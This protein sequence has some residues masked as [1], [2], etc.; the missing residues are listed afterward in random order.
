M[1]AARGILT[2]S[3][4]ILITLVVHLPAA[5]QQETD[6]HRR[7]SESIALS[8]VPRLVLTS[9][10]LQCII[11]NNGLICSSQQDLGGGGGWYPT[12]TP[13]DYI[14][15]SGFQIAGITADDAGPWARDTAGAY[16][17][18]A[19]F[20]IA[21]G[22]ALTQ[23][24]DSR[25]SDD[26]ENWPAGAYIQDAEIFA[27]ILLGRKTA[28]QHDTWFQYWDGDP[29]R[30]FE[31]SHPMG[32]K[33]T[34]RSM[35][36]TYPSG[37]ESV[38][39]FMLEFENATADPEFQRLN[40][41]AYFGGDNAL[42]DEGW[43][44]NDVYVAFA[45]DHDV[46]WALQNLATAI[47]PFNMTI[48]YHGGFNAPSY[49][50]ATPSISIPPFFATSPGIAGVKYLK[51]PNDQATGEELG[52]SMVSVVTN[53]QNTPF[54]D[55]IGIP[56]LWRYLAGEFDLSLGDPT[57][58]V[59]A[60]IVSLDASRVERSVCYVP[61]SAADIRFYQAS[62][63]F[64]LAPGEKSTVIA[65]HLVAPVVETMPDGSPSGVVQSSTNFNI[66]PPGVPSFH[67]GFASARGC[68]AEGLNCTDVLSA[69]ENPVKP[70]ERA[71]GWVGYSGP[72]PSGGRYPPQ[73][74]HPT[75]R[76]DQFGVEVV[77]GS[78]LGRA[79]VAQTV[80]ENDFLLG[81][82]PERPQFYLLPGNNQV[83][84]LWDPSRTETE[85]DPFYQIAGDPESAL[86]NP[87]YREFDVEG[88]RIWRSTDRGNLELIAQFD[89]ENTRY[90]DYTCETVHPEED[91]GV[92]SV[93][94]E[95]G[96][97]LPVIGYA[98]GEICPATEENP[99]VRSI[100]G[101]L[102]FNNGGP[103]GGPGA[104]VTRNPASVA[105]DT[106]ILADRDIGEVQPLADTGVPYVYVDT[107]VYN[108]FTYFYAVTAFDLNSMASGPHSLRSSRVDQ[109]VTP[110][111]DEQNL[112]VASFSTYLAGEDGQPLSSGEIPTVDSE[113]GRFASPFPPTTAY[114][115][116]FAPVVERLLGTG[117]T[118]AVID[119][120]Q[121]RASGNLA[122]GTQE[123]PPSETCTA[124]FEAGQLANAFGGCWRIFLTTTGSDGSEEA[125]EIGG[126]TPWWN[127]FGLPGLVRGQ[128]VAATVE[129][130]EEVLESFGIDEASTSAVIDWVTGESQNYTAAEG[131]QN[132]RRGV[133]ATGAR[134]IDGDTRQGAVAVEDPSAL[135]R[136][137]HLP[138][139][140]TVWAPIPYT[141]NVEGG[142]AV[143]GFES[144]C[145]NRAQAF[146]D[147]AA[148]VVWT[149]SGGTLTARDITHNVDVPFHP[150]AGPTW[151]FLTTDAN[152]NG[153]LDWHDFNYI[154]RAYQIMRQVD[155]G[156]C[157]AFAGGR[158][159]AAGTA[160]P[161]FL[162]A[163]PSL[164]PT[165]TEGMADAGSIDFENGA[166]PPQTGTGFGLYAY[167][168]RFIFETSSLP[169]DGTVWTLRTYKGEL[170]TDDD[171]L[172]NPTGY[173]Y[174]ADG[175]G[176][177]GADG[178]PLPAL[179]PGLQF[180]WDVETGT[181]VV[182]SWELDRV[183]TVPDPYLATSRYDFSPTTKQL[184]FVN[185]P[186]RASIRIYTLTGVLVDQIE[187]DDPTGGGR[188]VWDMRNRNNQFVASGVYFFH[189]VTP[190]GDERVGKF[191]ILIAT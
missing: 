44:Y 102:V 65:A 186:P 60:E 19:R 12:G 40:E 191:T 161:V 179:I 148:D 171:G 190:E 164:V 67:P 74:E 163:T 63:P 105:I 48:A 90:T 24:Y 174:V 37:N 139:V 153:V 106:A 55:P 121:M 145:M 103:G 133:Y 146:N 182:A 9:N 150:S 84:V 165:S 87:N 16:F 21:H 166:A 36:W 86:Y 119:S 113:T 104:G 167:G 114:R 77:P 49:Y 140:D 66:N 46:G 175:A 81:F 14:F 138:Q 187:H 134:W 189:L 117:V 53:F 95:T 11:L 108:N 83:T 125:S 188:A 97:T 88:Y 110:R 75:N 172:A 13:N 136:V 135:I 73:V 158:F 178:G 141:P 169:A 52:L 18:D 34:Q 156:D 41:L 20:N 61:N 29:A 70:I 129:Y 126:Y 1:A 147:R 78:L 10:D 54:P 26:L 118:R 38:I 124:Q 80:F 130:S 143:G 151:G 58:N 7:A 101:D 168:H 6:K 76:L 72:P 144:Q 57:C 47:L 39:Y 22:S 137:G 96:D 157:N 142:D 25:D 28:S 132:R 27:P 51:S 91:V 154:D 32:I 155:G 33:I 59:P 2:L 185:L 68:D 184:M 181:E 62:G 71:S 131:T 82:A 127:A 107:E 149:W 30:T 177:G 94:P 116:T 183:H 4:A 159:D 3:G 170:V 109:A 123:F 176:G 128:H 5:A 180:V 23:I 8:A 45:A 15:N 69:A 111:Q 31:R 35:S 85:G 50:Q 17:F 152:G 112:T 160:S 100:D 79:L 89:F 173:T 56:Q 115:S 43:S 92:L 98:A 42:P 120:I 93:I 64:S 162:T 122:G 99:L